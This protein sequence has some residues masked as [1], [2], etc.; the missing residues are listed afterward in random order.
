MS[1]KEFVARQL[2][3]HCESPSGVKQDTYTEWTESHICDAL[4]LG[5]CYLYSLIPQEFS[6]L[7]TYTVSEGTCV[8]DLS[9]QCERFISLV[10]MSIGDTQCVDLNQ[11]DESEDED[12]IDLLP[13]LGDLCVSESA[14]SSDDENN[15]DEEITYNWTVADGSTSVLK[16]NPDIPAGTVLT[17]LCAPT[18]SI[19][20]IDDANLCQY[21]SMI[22]DYALWWL[23]RTDSESRSN[24]ERATLH[25]QA[26]QFFVETKLR[27]E[28]SLREDDYNYGSRK[29]A[30]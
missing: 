18:P 16:F 11:E 3:D 5:L 15:D 14:S 28:F 21:H 22:A 2:N 1:L 4:Q 13:L 25:F 27:I 23:F 17:Y 29:V 7:K 26:V 19:E 10:N 9:S 30:D 8:V 6:E 20:T 24:L 12:S